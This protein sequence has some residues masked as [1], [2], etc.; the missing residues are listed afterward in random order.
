MASGPKVRA[1]GATTQRPGRPD[2]RFGG[3]PAPTR[4]FGPDAKPATGDGR[5]KGKKSRKNYVD[6]EAVQANILKTLAGMKG[7]VRK[8]R[9]D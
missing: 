6:Q 8:R 2:G 4:T 7:G 9:A 3:P 5:R 1:G